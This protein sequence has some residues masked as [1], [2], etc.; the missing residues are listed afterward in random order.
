MELSSQAPVLALAAGEVVTLDDARG[1]RIHARE[2]SVWVTEEA[3]S[4]DHILATGDAL[5][6]GRGGRTVIQALQA[7][8]VAL[9]DPVPANDVLEGKTA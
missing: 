2:G 5:I 7:S 3:N 6:V 9:R 1:V 8:W 4:R